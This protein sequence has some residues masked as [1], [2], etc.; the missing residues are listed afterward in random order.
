MKSTVFIYVLLLIA[1]VSD[2]R[3]DDGP[4]VALGPYRAALNCENDVQLIM[5]LNLT[6]EYYTWSTYGNGELIV[7]ETGPWEQKENELCLNGECLTIRNIAIN[8]FEVSI[9]DPELVTLC[10]A[11]WMIFIK[12]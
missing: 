2:T 6:S 12:Q 8:T 9:D 7:T 4:S 5:D 3:D 1:C 11:T 10:S